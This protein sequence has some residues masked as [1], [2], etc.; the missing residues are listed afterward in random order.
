MIE[1]EFLIRLF[2]ANDLS[3]VKMN[4]VS[5]E[6]KFKH[7]NELYIT[8]YQSETISY[9]SHLNDINCHTAYS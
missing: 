5:F 2:H 4:K 9:I 7:A 8:F 1:Q 3:G 6:F